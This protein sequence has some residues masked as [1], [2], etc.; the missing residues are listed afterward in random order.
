MRTDWAGRL[1]SRAPAR[2]DTVGLGSAVCFSVLRWLA[3]R[4]RGLARATGFQP[5]PGTGDP[6]AFDRFPGTGRRRVVRARGDDQ[7]GRGEILGQNSQHQAAVVAAHQRRQARLRPFGRC[8][9]LASEW[10]AHRHGP[11]AQARVADAT[12]GRGG[13][14]FGQGSCA[15]DAGPDYRSRR[16]DRR[17]RGDDPWTSALRCGGAQRRGGAAAVRRGA[18]GRGSGRLRQ[19]GHHGLG[20]AVRHRLRHGAVGP[21]GLA[22]PQGQGHDP[23]VRATRRVDRDRPVRGG[24]RFS[25]QHA[26]GGAGG[27]GGPRHGAVAGPVAQAVPDAAQLCGHHG[28]SADPDRHLDQSAGQRHGPQYGSAG[29]LSV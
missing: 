26:G 18:P 21:A 16:P 11:S 7:A 8:C 22:D 29:L 10:K 28:R 4:R 27:A 9:A 15:G 25:Q 6:E 3:R 5:A 1:G 23:P 14:R 2:N 20:G 24:R 13:S 17:G 12:V 19:P